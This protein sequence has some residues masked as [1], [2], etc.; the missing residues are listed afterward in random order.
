MTCFIVNR[1]TNNFYKMSGFALI[2]AIATYDS[3]Y[4][5]TLFTQSTFSMTC[6]LSMPYPL[7]QYLY[8]HLLCLSCL[9]YQY[10]L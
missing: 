7:C 3:L 5:D 4:F 10:F 9:V 1:K 6:L 2:I 8:L